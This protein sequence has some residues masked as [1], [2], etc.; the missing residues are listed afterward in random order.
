MKIKITGS[1]GLAW[2]AKHVGEE[3][4]VNSVTVHVRPGLPYTSYEVNL[5]GRHRNSISGT[6]PDLHC[7]VTD[8]AG[9]PFGKAHT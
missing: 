6:V 3:F 4:T 5:I 1:D 2:Y 7:K 8:W 9:W